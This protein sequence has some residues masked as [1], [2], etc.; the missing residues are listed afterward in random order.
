MNFSH[1]VAQ[2]IAFSKDNSFTKVIIRIAMAT[3]AVSVTVMIMASAVTQGFK[4]E[5]SDKIFGFWGHIHITDSNI[6]RFF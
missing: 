3:V 4:K 1:F 5:I 2:K 6:T